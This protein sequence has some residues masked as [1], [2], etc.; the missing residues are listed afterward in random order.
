MELWVSHSR[1]N[2]LG[3]YPCVGIFLSCPHVPE[4]PVPLQGQLWAG[5][6]SIRLPSSSFIVKLRKKMWACVRNGERG[7]WWLKIAC[8]ENTRRRCFRIPAYPACQQGWQ[9]TGH[10]ERNNLEKSKPQAVRAGHPTCWDRR[11]TPVSRETE[12]DGSSWGPPRMSQVTGAEFN[13]AY[14]SDACAL[15]E[16]VIDQKVRM[17]CIFSI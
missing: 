1:L 15:L 16:R 2:F 17:C 3:G 12:G 9:N 7:M 14:P 10:W 5:F 8:L 4:G 6:P 11:P 13:T